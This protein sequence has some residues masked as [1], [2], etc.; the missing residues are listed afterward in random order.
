MVLTFPYHDPSGK[1]NS[2]FKKNF[3]ILKK[4]F[5]Q[6]FISIT[7]LTYKQNKEF[8]NLLSSEG[9]IVYTNKVDS[10]IG[11]HFRSALSISL[12]KITS[13]EQV[14]FSFIDR[15]LYILESE[16]AEDFIKDL[17]QAE[18]GKLT[19]FERSTKAWNSHPEN[20]REMEEFVNSLLKRFSGLDLE[21]NFCALMLNKEIAGKILSSS[22]SKGWEVPGEWLLLAI[23]NSLSI[24]TKKVDWLSWED[25]FWEKVDKYQLMKERE[26]SKDETLKRIKTNL[27]FLKLLTEDRFEGIY[28]LSS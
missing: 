23:K 4:I 3:S 17:K 11:D 14:F 12:K 13:K 25:P 9:M 26:K 20:Y 19:I 5:N 10:Y 16:N 28:N 7:P 18:V 8:I 27:P 22:Q 6:I 15:I 1:Y 21:V 2:I 24:S